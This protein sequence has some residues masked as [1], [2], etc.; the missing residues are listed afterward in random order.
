MG[1]VASPSSAKSP[2]FAHIRV[3]LKDKLE[4]ILSSLTSYKD[5]EVVSEAL[6]IFSKDTTF[7]V[8]RYCY[9]CQ[10]SYCNVLLTA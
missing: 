4:A 6:K 5:T 10:V 9:L 3:L 8:E 2:Q 7:L 1:C